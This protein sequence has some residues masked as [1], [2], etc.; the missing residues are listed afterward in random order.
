M[1]ERTAYATGTQL[2]VQ[3]RTGREHHDWR[4]EALIA[5]LPKGLQPVVRWMREPSARWVR[6]PV[7]MLLIAGGVLSILPFLG[8][9]MLPLGIILLAEDV[10][11]FRRVTDK[12]LDWVERRRPHWFKQS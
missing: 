11:L 9:W 3:P 4:L 1:T 6:I 7:G 2:V 5:H 10:P 8:I 12:G